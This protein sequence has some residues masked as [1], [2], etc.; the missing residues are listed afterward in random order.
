[1]HVPFI[2][3]PKLYTEYPVDDAMKACLVT[4]KFILQE[5]VEKFENNFARFLGVKHFIGLNSGTDALMLALIA[6]GVGPGDEVITVSNTFIATIQVIHHLGATPVLVDV[7]E[8]GLMDMDLVNMAITDKTKVV[9][10]VHLSGDMADMLAL[11][12]IVTKENQKRLKEFRD[13]AIPV[14]IVEDAAQAIGAD[15]DGIKA[16][17]FY[18]AIGCFSF[19]PAKVLGTFGDAGG[20]ATSDDAVAERVRGLRNHGNVSKDTQE[21]YEF[22]W[23]SRLDNVWAAVLNVKLDFLE[24]D[25]KKRKAV[26]D[27]YNKEL[28]GLP[29]TLP[30]NREGRIWQDYIIRTSDEIERKA[31]T[32]HLTEN[33]I[34]FL[35]TDL[36]PNHLYPGLGLDHFVLPVTEKIVMT[37][38][39]IPCNHFMTQEQAYYVSQVIK[40][41]YEG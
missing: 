19:Y 37:S 40:D 24:L 23:N 5:E 29:I 34:G 2:E 36:L 12:N 1:M 8:D 20:L 16:G 11:T 18:P 28:Q 35:G 38:I 26:A 39:R 22:G 41:F 17:S 10:P 6:A 27:L 4:G 9:I 13:K 21:T 32:D 14:R 31:L 3:Y 25:L 15:M 30:V 7:G 33:G